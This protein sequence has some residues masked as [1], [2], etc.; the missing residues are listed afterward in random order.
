MTLI[1]LIIVLSLSVAGCTTLTS[2]ESAS[3]AE[4]V[5]E[6]IQ[7]GWR[8]AVVPAYTVPVSLSVI[9]TLHYVA[10]ELPNTLA[11]T[12]C[13]HSRHTMC[14]E[15]RGLSAG[16]ETQFHSAFQTKSRNMRLDAVVQKCQGI[17]GQ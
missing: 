15:V 7:D 2:Y 10:V 14:A 9:E 11:P 8:T 13:Y 6:C 12:S 4:V 5:A 16:S 3:A 1:I 17:G